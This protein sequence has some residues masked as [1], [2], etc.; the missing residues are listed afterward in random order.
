MRR[1]ARTLSA[2]PLMKRGRELWEQNALQWEM[3]L[4]KWDKLWCGGYIILKDYSDHIFPP[5]FEDQSKAYENEINYTKS[6][7]GYSVEQARVA[8]ST[9]PLWGAKNST[10]YMA[11]FN[12]LYRMLES[13]GVRPPQ[14]LLEMGC[15]CGW[16]AEFLATAGY[17]VVGT[18]I[19]PIEINWAKEKVAALACKQAKGQLS[20]LAEPMESVDNIPGAR[21]TF[22]AVYVYEALHHAYD[23]RKSLQASSK[24]LKKGGWLL[25]A[26]EP[27]VLHTFISYRVS[28]LSKTHEIGFHRKELLQELKASGF[29]RIDVLAPKWNNWI[30]AFWI[31]AQKS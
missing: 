29:D 28:R 16:M 17:S 2:S 19:S 8:C 27:N 10:R 11:Q 15:G 1:L 14:K 18:S 7:P 9:K 24:L 20:F 25:L 30:R 21:G 31:M 26:N 23:W 6:L 13:A 22:D 5:K 12:Q 4:T 3:P